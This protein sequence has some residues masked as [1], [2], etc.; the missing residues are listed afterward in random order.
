MMD[1]EFLLIEKVDI[2]EVSAK[3]ENLLC[4]LSFG[5]ISEDAGLV[6]RLLFAFLS[7]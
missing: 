5:V 6:N 3:A 2:G 7:L 4:G 1:V